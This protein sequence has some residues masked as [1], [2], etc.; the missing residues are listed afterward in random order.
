MRARGMAHHQHLIRALT[1]RLGERVGKCGHPRL[2]RGRVG[3]TR[4]GGIGVVVHEVVGKDLAILCLE[5]AQC[6]DKS[7]AAQGGPDPG[8]RAGPDRATPTPDQRPEQ[9]GQQQ[10]PQQHPHRVKCRD[11]R[12]LA[13]AHQPAQRARRDIGPGGAHQLQVGGG[14][15][16]RHTAPN[17]VGPH[18][19]CH[20][21]PGL[22]TVDHSIHM[23]AVMRPLGR[24]RQRQVVARDARLCRTFLA[25]ELAVT[26]GMNRIVTGDVK[27]PAARNGLGMRTAHL[28]TFWRIVAMFR[29]QSKTEADT[30]SGRFPTR[31]PGA[32]PSETASVS[33]RFPCRKP[34][35]PAWRAP[36][37]ARAARTRT[38]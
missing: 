14:D 37:T 29:G 6:G 20:I 32:A 11:H 35:S 8:A 21:R 22:R 18:K 19:D 28:C 38:R 1:Q 17:D 25:V 12:P 30:A 7:G 16:R 23:P 26:T 33:S 24:R 2:E 10:L 36:E 4:G 31:K 34:I 27:H 5:P 15:R 3:A 9:Q 13:Q